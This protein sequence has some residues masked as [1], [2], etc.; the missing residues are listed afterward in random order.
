MQDRNNNYSGWT[1]FIGAAA[2]AA[3]GFWLN[4]DKGRIWRAE[5]SQKVNETGQKISD[6]AAEQ[7]ET[8]KSSVNTAIDNSKSY[9][10]QIT[11]KAKDLA[12]KYTNRT[13]RVVTEKVE[14]IESAYEK[15]ANTAKTKINNIS[16]NNA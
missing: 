1:F 2:G 3:L 9:V 6:G 8:T 7:W 4:S 12:S 14:E 5:T 15:G 16:T 11:D 13:E 10:N